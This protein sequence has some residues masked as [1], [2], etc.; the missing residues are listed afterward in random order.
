MTEVD[1]TVV[2][3]C[4]SNDLNHSGDAVES[5]DFWSEDM[6]DYCEEQM[7]FLWKMILVY[8]PGNHVIFI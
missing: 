4:E 5:A 7:S 3:N 1:S 2:S 8:D 6:T